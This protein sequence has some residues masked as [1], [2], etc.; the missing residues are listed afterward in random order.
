MNESTNRT[1]RRFLGTQEQAQHKVTDKGIGLKEKLT[2]GVSI[3][4]L[5]ITIMVGYSNVQ[6][7]MTRM[8]ERVDSLQST[9]TATLSVLNRLAESVDRLSHIVTRL[10]ERTKVLEREGGY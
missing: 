7:D 5:F 3:V 10:D 1:T 8:Q 4:T 2:A 6:S 9:N